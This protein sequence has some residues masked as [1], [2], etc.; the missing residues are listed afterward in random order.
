MTPGRVFISEKNN[1]IINIE[2]AR[3]DKVSFNCSFLS[4]YKKIVIKDRKIEPPVRIIRKKL[5]PAFKVDILPLVAVTFCSAPPKNG[6]K[7]LRNEQTAANNN[8]R[9]CWRWI[10]IYLLSK[11]RQ[12]DE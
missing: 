3:P 4:L 2:I 9:L 12:A 6:N 11:I 5:L 10:I 8:Q 1:T 7:K